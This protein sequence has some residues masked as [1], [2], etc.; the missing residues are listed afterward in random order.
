M[1]ACAKCGVWHGR[2][3]KGTW[4]DECAKQENIS[5]VRKHRRGVDQETFDK[6]LTVQG[7]RCAICGTKTPGG[8]GNFHV[9]H[10]H[11][12]GKVRGLLCVC[13]NVCLGYA[14][15]NPVLLRSAADYLER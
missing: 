15:D 1:K 11:K 14:K 3:A 12:T 6:M 4:C 8:R 10:D 13:C 5:S 7:G 2:Q 9:D